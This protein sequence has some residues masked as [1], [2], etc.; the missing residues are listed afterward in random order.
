MT[1]LLVRMPSC[2]AAVPVVVID[3][4]GQTLRVRLATRA[5]VQPPEFENGVI[6]VRRADV[7]REVR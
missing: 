7:V 2:S 1:T 4:H 3:D 5:I 6:V